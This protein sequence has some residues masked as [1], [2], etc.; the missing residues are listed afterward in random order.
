MFGFGF[1]VGAIVFGAAG[2]GLTYLWFKRAK[3]QA[4]IAAK[5]NAAT[6]AVAGVKK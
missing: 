5:V 2:W 6:A 1:V 3:I 4:K